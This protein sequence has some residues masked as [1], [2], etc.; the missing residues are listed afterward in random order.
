MSKTGEAQQ[1]YHSELVLR[2]RL[3]HAYAEARRLVFD[4]IDGPPDPATL[5]ARQLAAL[6]EFDTAE[7]A[8]HALRDA[9]RAR[10]D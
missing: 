7:A 6:E 9:R 2:D 4:V 1:I 3:E 10:A 8:L 5:T